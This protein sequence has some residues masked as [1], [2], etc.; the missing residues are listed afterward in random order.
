MGIEDS[1]A[2]RHTGDVPI[3][4]DRFSPTELQE[5]TRVRQAIGQVVRGLRE[6]RRMSQA[7]VAAAANIS[8]RELRRIEGGHGGMQLDRLWPLARALETTP[9][10]IVY[11]AQRLAEQPQD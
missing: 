9:A 7:D 10:E 11:A 5:R 2:G 1:P 8:E 4:D 3:A 6:A